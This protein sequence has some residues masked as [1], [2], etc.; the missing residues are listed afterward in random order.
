MTTPEIVIEA[1]RLRL[2]SLA[3][4]PPIVLPNEEIK[5]AAPYLIYD[6]GFETVTPITVDGEERYQFN[7]QVSIMVEHGAKPSAY[8]GYVSVIR[9]GFK[10]GVRLTDD[11]AQYIA[12]CRTSP[13]AFNGRPD[14]GLYRVDVTLN[15]VSHLKF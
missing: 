2:F 15:V 4:L 9:E 13:T 14:N 8:S 1:I 3:G 6:D 11:A 12:D 7:P 5:L 10:S